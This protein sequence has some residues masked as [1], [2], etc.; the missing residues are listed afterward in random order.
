MTRCIIYLKLIFILCLC[1][2]NAHANTH[3][4][5]TKDISKQSLE[6]IFYFT[7]KEK[8]QQA[9]RFAKKTNNKTAIELVDWLQ[10]KNSDQDVT[11]GAISQFIA[12]HP[13]WPDQDKLIHHRE[14]AL[15]K[16]NSAKKIR[17][18][19]DAHPPQTAIG[20]EVYA[21]AR[22]EKEK[23][24]SKKTKQL[25][26]Q[27]WAERNFYASEQGHF[28]NTYKKILTHQDHVARIDR[29]LWERKITQAKIML[30]KVNS[31]YKKLFLARIALQSSKRGVD[32][33]VA[34][35]PKALKKDPGLLYERIRWKDKRKRFD[36]VA[37]LLTQAKGPMPYQSKWWKIKNL[38]VRE[39]LEKKRYKEAYD[40]LKNHGNTE[41]TREFADAQWLA[42]WLALRFLKHPAEAYKH[43]YQ[44][45]VHVKY[46]ISIA[47]ASYWAARAAEANQNKAIAKNWFKVAA[48]HKTTFYGQ[49]AY[50]ELHQDKKP[51][52]PENP[53]IKAKDKTKYK[54]NDL[55]KAA[56][57]FVKAGKPKWAEKFIKA[58]IKN[59]NDEAQ[60]FLISE[61]GSH[62]QTP[63]LSIIAVKQAEIKGK[64]FLVGYPSEKKIPK[65][66]AEESLVL[67]VIRQESR[68]NTTAVSPANAK[69]LM[70]IL[71]STARRVAKK[72]RVK[73]S[74]RALTQKPAYN[75]LLGSNY[76]SGLIKRF[77]KSY[78]LS[79]AAYNAGPTNV[80]KWIK[81]FGDPR[82]TNNIHNII[83]WLE[84]IPFKETRNY[85]QR[86]L[87]NAQFYRHISQKTGFKTKEDLTR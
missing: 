31:S 49:L 2:A 17:N 68:F 72:L 14:K 55:M 52:L 38:Y 35:V 71:P 59:T 87:E 83:D 34:M 79:I 44:L 10:F 9:R 19:F 63:E 7:K 23:K 78:I 15:Q 16:E 75:I 58:A 24:I 61:F 6:K 47:R 13:N 28:Y 4:F 62:H 82:K 66:A 20:K 74:T 18:Y 50:T 64:V 85:V 36:Q 80:K 81:K 84:L 67:G 5:N 21:K 51:T 60:M 22:I 26:K 53:P 39:L 41:G 29:L 12:N 8:Y 40:I 32:K 46:P 56:A 11:F 45:F 3:D 27:A 30:A 37:Y 86:V 33:R 25:I 73:Y 76:L 70:Q 69:G 77:D 1:F 65:T 57:L 48:R 43:F 42:G 54:N